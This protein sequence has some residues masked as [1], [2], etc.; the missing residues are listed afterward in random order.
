M[1]QEFYFPYIIERDQLVAG[2]R[3]LNERVTEAELIEFYE[4]FSVEENGI[5]LVACAMCKLY[6][7]EECLEMLKRCDE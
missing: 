2:F 4:K 5:Y 6:T 7:R 1:W 3:G